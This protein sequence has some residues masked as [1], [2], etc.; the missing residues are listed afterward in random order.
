MKT[1]ILMRHAKAVRPWEAAE[2]R[3]RGLTSRGRD[4]A[5]ETATALAAAGFAPSLAL[6]SPAARTQQTWELAQEIWPDAHAREVEALYMASPDDIEAEA[7]RAGGDVTLVIG[8][9]PGLKDLARWYIS[10]GEGHDRDGAAQLEDG[11]LTA[12]ASVF[13]VDERPARG[14][15]RLLRVITPHHAAN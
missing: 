14:R 5:R 4:D 15:T 6:Y 3:L 8:H 1:L 11:F 9:N 7:T 13:A 10:S 12:S 2:D